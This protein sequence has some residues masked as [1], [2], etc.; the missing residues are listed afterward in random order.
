M[1]DYDLYGL[2]PVMPFL[3]GCCTGLSQPETKRFPI[4]YFGNLTDAGTRSMHYEKMLMMTMPR[5]VS[6]AS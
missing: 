6:Y 2:L 1:F 5:D 3:V 4:K